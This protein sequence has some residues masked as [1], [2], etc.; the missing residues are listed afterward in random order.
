MGGALS[1]LHLYISEGQTPDYTPPTIRG[2]WDY[3]TLSNAYKMLA[4]KNADG[5]DTDTYT[6]YYTY[7][8]KT[9]LDF[10]GAYTLPTAI[11]FSNGAFTACVGGYTNNAGCTAYLRL[12]A[13]VLV[14]QTDVVRCTLFNGTLGG[15]AFATNST[16]TG[17]TVAATCGASCAAQSG[18]TLIVEFGF[19]WYADS[20]G[21][22]LRNSY[23]AIN[24]SDLTDGG[25]GSAH[26]SW[27][28]FSYAAVIDRSPLIFCGR[29]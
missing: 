19:Q 23:G 21:Y 1:N 29:C 9:A 7:T 12:M 5:Q 17:R 20:N 10:R 2:G 13:F 28:D 27:V 18:D 4:A 15:T 26:P 22:L 14:G 16:Y 11:D 24:A 6:E 25:D 3:T 8:N